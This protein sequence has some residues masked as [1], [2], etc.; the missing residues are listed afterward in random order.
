MP[1]RELVLSEAEQREVAVT[2]L[3]NNLFGVAER[4]EDYITLKSKRL[5][6]HYLDIRPGLSSYALRCR[7]TDTMAGLDVKGYYVLLDREEGGAPQVAEATGI[8]IT[9]ALGVSSMVRILRADGLL[10]QTQYDNVGRY[11]TEFGDPHAQEAMNT[12]L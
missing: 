9:P 2:L 1:S 8:D 7:I 4:P 3:N 6:P 12:T 5:S 10:N 11:L